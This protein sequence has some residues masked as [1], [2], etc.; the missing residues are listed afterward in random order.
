MHREAFEKK[1]RDA[2]LEKMKELY[3][4]KDGDMI[5]R[6]HYSTILA[7]KIYI[8][9]QFEDSETGHEIV[10]KLNLLIEKK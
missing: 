6:D 5:E 7:E 4:G 9:L 8:L 10:R 2:F 3:K 1:R